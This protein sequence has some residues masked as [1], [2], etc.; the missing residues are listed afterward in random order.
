MSK[1]GRASQASICLMRLWFWKRGMS[2]VRMGSAW[3]AAVCATAI[4]IWGWTR[5]W[6]MRT[7]WWV[8]G[9]WKKWKGIS[10]TGVERI[11]GI[12]IG[13]KMLQWDTL[14]LPVQGGCVWLLPYL[15]PIGV[16]VFDFESDKWFSAP[17]DCKLDSIIGVEGVPKNIREPASG[18]DDGENK[19]DYKINKDVIHHFL[20]GWW[21]LYSGKFL[22]VG[23]F[24]GS[25]Q[26]LCISQ[27]PFQL[28]RIFCCRIPFPSDQEG[29]ASWFSVMSQ[30][31]AY[32]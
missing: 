32:L 13:R 24:I 6:A 11:E 20:I 25:D 22:C 2:W 26:Q 1:R 9:R 7:S 15:L 31:I 14:C 8:M 5:I 4:A 10:Y 16:K 27:V 29:M 19:Q 17:S 21:W 18:G 23:N 3:K 12:V 30:D 28:P